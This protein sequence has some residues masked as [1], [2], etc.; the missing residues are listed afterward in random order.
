[1]EEGS[2]YSLRSLQWE[3]KKWKCNSMDVEYASWTD[4]PFHPR[5]CF[6]LVYRQFEVKLAPRYQVMSSHYSTIT[7]FECAKINGTV[8]NY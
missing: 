7:G 1:M 2:F 3:K 5:I 6:K 8:K 4:G